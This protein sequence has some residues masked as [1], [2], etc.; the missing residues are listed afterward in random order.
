MEL[1][2]SCQ[3]SM[4]MFYSML[5]EDLQ[6]WKFIYWYTMHSYTM[7]AL[8]VQYKGCLIQKLA[9]RQAHAN[10]DPLISNCWKLLESISLLLLLLQLPEA[11]CSIQQSLSFI[12]YSLRV[13]EIQ[14]R[15]VM[16]AGPFSNLT[17]C[18]VRRLIE[19]ALKETE[20]YTLT[21]I[22]GTQS[23]NIT[24]HKHSFS[25]SNCMACTIT[26]VG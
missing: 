24:L 10:P 19:P 5:M 26:L 20:N 4:L 17:S 25:E 18:A 14:G 1:N 9:S 15:L 23:R 12:Y 21:V 7:H 22:V 6:L 13:E 3:L 2:F 8:Y 16:S 11:L